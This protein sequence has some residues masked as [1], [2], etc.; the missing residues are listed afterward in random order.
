VFFNFF[1]VDCHVF[2]LTTFYYARTCIGI[3]LYRTMARSS[4]KRERFFRP[5]Q[6]RPSTES[7]TVFLAVKSFPMV[8][9][10]NCHAIWILTKSRATISGPTGSSRIDCR[11]Y[12]GW[13]CKSN[14]RFKTL[15][16][17]GEVLYAIL[18]VSQNTVH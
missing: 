11:F 14:Y 15:T 6:N 17:V 12:F 10:Q 13:P 16:N 3:F 2:T 9:L 8:F 5:L 18:P 7:C 1:P 4:Y